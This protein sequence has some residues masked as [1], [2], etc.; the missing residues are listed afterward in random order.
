MRCLPIILAIFSVIILPHTSF[1]QG[2]NNQSLSGYW[3]MNNGGNANANLLKIVP[4]K[5]CSLTAS[6]KENGKVRTLT[7]M[8]YENRYLSLVENTT[9]ENK[10]V[11]TG[12]MLQNGVISGNYYAPNCQY[13]T[14]SWLK[15]CDE[16]GSPLIIDGEEILPCVEQTR[17]IS[18]QTKTITTTKKVVQQ[19]V[20]K[21]EYV[22]EPRNE[23]LPLAQ[24]TNFIPDG[25]LFAGNIG[26]SEKVTYRTVEVEVPVEQPAVCIPKEE[27]VTVRG[28]IIKKKFSI[29][30]AG[31]TNPTGERGIVIPGKKVVEDGITYHIVGKG[32]TMFSI[33]K[34][35]KLT[36]LALAELNGKDCEHLVV[37]ERLRVSQSE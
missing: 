21:T 36:V 7:G 22:G 16:L 11:Y 24:T 14:F 37:N 5:S 12:E 33:A 18:E 30:D 9:N 3:R 20:D 17:G 27:T 29:C 6:F 26:L 32:E 34:Q 35:Y 8:F 25:A 31:T 1:A 10:L 28:E 15:V 2:T 23:N 13:G 19:V 4:S